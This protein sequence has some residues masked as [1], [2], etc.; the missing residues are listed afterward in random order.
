MVVHGVASVMYDRE[1][2]ISLTA[3]LGASFLDSVRILDAPA[4]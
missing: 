3:Q 4:R 1:C 2:N